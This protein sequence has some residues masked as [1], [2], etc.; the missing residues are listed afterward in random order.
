M[1]DQQSSPIAVHVGDVGVL[2]G[3][4]RPIAITDYQHHAELSEHFEQADDHDGPAGYVF[5]AVEQGLEWP[6]LAS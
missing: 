3:L 2:V 6:R 5:V 4:A 1:D